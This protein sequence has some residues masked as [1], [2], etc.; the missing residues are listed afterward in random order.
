[1][2]L[3]CFLQPGERSAYSLD[4]EEG[5]GRN[6]KWALAAE[7]SADQRAAETFVLKW[8]NIQL[9]LNDQRQ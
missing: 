7:T 9:K 1:M 6:L 8:T 2:G 3:R 5:P 4:W